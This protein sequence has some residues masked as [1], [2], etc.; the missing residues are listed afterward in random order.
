MTGNDDAIVP[1]GTNVPYQNYRQ[2]NQKSSYD[3]ASHY[4]RTNGGN[5]H[6]PPNGWYANQLAYH[7][8]Y[9]P[10]TPF[11]TIPLPSPI[12]ACMSSSGSLTAESGDVENSWNTHLYHCNNRLPRP[13]THYHIS[14]VGTHMNNLPREYLNNDELNIGCKLLF[15]IEA[16]TC[17]AGKHMWVVEIIEGITTNAKEIVDSS[18]AFGGLPIANVN[19]T[20]DMKETGETVI[21]EVNHCVFLGSK[22]TDGI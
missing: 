3:T 5:G 12:R 11:V 6:L 21:I 22:K 17:V 15:D 20:V 16:D 10:P 14:E 1:D 13:R 19:Y 9:N 18:Q 2:Y 7:N 8:N 4:S